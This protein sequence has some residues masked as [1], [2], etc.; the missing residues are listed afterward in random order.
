MT[1]I[2]SIMQTSDVLHDSSRMIEEA[3]Q[4]RGHG[5]PDVRLPLGLAAKPPRQSQEL[6]C[7][8]Q[9][10]LRSRRGSPECAAS[11]GQPSQAHNPQP[12]TDDVPDDTPFRLA[13]HQE[14][15]RSRVAS[16]ADRWPG[17]LH[18]ARAV[19]ATPAARRIRLLSSGM[20]TVATRRTTATRRRRRFKTR[21][22]SARSRATWRLSFRRRPGMYP[23]VVYLPGLGESPNA[24]I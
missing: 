13:L 7:R 2:S 11:G 21:G 16:P 23:L 24:G 17:L 22:R 14:R 6:V 8:V 4:S 19:A 10:V 12:L 3:K 5:L 20:P 1:A 9:H 18:D 15:V